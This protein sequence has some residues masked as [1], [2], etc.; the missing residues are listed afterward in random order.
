[1]GIESD[2][3]VYDYLSRVGDLAQQQQLSSGTRMRL[4]SE[5]RGEIDRQRVAQA[6][7]TPGAVRRI[8]GKLGTPDELVAAAARSADGAP[9]VPVPQEPDRG[10]AQAAGIPRPRRARLRKD[11]SRKG[12]SEALGEARG[13]AA[14]TSSGPVPSPPHRAGSDE[15]GPSRDD[16][17]WWSVAP[18]RFGDT[19]EFGAGTDVP[20]FR[21]GVE[22][23]A[24]LRPPVADDDEDEA[25]EDDAYEDDE[26]YEEE[27]EEPRRRRRL[28]RLRRARAEDA[29]PRGFSHPL[30]LLAAV[31]LVA[32]AV[33]DTPQALLALAGG[34]LLAYSSR[35][36]SRAEAKWAVMGLPG[37]VAVGALVWLWGRMD[38]RWGAPIAEGRMGP[39]IGDTW[40]WVV[41]GAAVA[42]ALYLVWRAR[43]PRPGGR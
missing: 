31:L 15:L 6:A 43:G 12:A 2:Q 17:D 41:R 39:A 22:I 18:G 20:G 42:S 29:A 38:G 34:W 7:D 19:G 40:P 11:S 24:V 10:G 35:K 33:I 9:P 23:P 13:E 26:A 30:L 32:G 37:V 14:R 25:Y 28:P 5:L 27:A 36:L 4:V 8:I 16:A 21:G 3:L 1:M